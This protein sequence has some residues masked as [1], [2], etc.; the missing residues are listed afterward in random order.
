MKHWPLNFDFQGRGRWENYH[1]SH[2]ITQKCADEDGGPV[3]KL[4]WLSPLLELCCFCFSPSSWFAINI[5]LR[6]LRFNILFLFELPPCNWT[7][8]AEGTCSEGKVTAVV[9]LTI[10]ID[11]WNNYGF[12]RVCW[13][14]SLTPHLHNRSG[15]VRCR[16]LMIE[17]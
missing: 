8:V 4:Q 6:S 11:W 17:G 13:N 3:T 2:S 7:E 14:I 1:A 5:F 16:W 10:N 12:L 9:Q 15:N